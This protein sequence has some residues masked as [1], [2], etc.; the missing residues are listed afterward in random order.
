M[1]GYPDVP[2][3]PSRPSRLTTLPGMRFKLISPSTSEVWQQP[4]NAG[5]EREEILRLLEGLRTR[6]HDNELV[7]GDAISA[8]QR[9]D[10]YGE[11]FLALAHGGNRYR[12]RQVFGSRRHG[13]GDHLGLGVPALIVFEDDEPVD[14]YPH[15]VGDGYRT[16]RAYLDSL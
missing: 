3:G 2:L 8:E 1:E 7:D 16:I 4:A 13:G 9:R 10:L 14:V 5:F 6:G 15:Q 12:I 11:A